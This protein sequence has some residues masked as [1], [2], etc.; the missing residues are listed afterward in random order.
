VSDFASFENAVKDDTVT[1]I[2]LG[3]DITIPKKISVKRSTDLIIDGNNKTYTLIEDQTLPA[4]AS[5]YTMTF[6]GSYQNL[7]FRNIKMQ[8]HSYGASV[9]A[10]VENVRVLFDNVEYLGPALYRGVSKGN[11]GVLKD[12]DITLQVLSSKVKY[13]SEAMHV[14]NAELT[15][16][17][18]IKK[19]PSQGNDY[20]EIFYFPNADGRLIVDKNADVRIE[21]LSAAV[22]SRYWSGLLYIDGGAANT[23]A[24]VVREGARFSYEGM[25]GCI[26]EQWPLDEFLIEK[27][28][29]VDM[30]LS[31][32]SGKSKFKVNDNGAYLRAKRIV[33]EEG[34]ALHYALTGDVEYHREAMLGVDD[35]TVGEG[36]VLRV[37][38]A[39][40]AT[41]ENIV[42]FYGNNPRMTLNKPEDVLFYNGAQ[43]TL[44]NA[45]LSVAQKGD[46]YNVSA[47][48]P[49]ALSFTGK[50]ISAW[51]AGNTKTDIN[52]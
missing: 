45:A 10:P 27:G 39:D 4:N 2:T 46:G 49:I 3:S 29:K 8:G 6:A 14:S 50:G 51:D 43:T 22:G 31:I 48:A 36:A 7:T 47:A 18:R 41:A 19:M 24:F 33:L 11:T 28:A 9:S 23:H 32:P 13:T 40:N 12:S 16:N 17:V 42:R 52:G 25:G 20:D 1:E 15:G 5:D 38:A 21:N 26:I 34:A 30:R 37:K 35:L 44:P